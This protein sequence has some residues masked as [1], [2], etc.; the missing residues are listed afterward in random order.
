ME[1]SQTSFLGRGWS[2]PPTFDPLTASVRMVSEEED[3]IESLFILFTTRP[4]ERV[5]HPRYGCDLFSQVFERIDTLTETF[6]EGLI[7]DA[8]LYFEPRI[9]LEEV[10][11]NEDDAYDGLL[12]IRLVY[13]VRKTNSRSNV[14]FPFYLR[15][16][17]HV[18]RE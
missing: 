3:I 4:G 12:Y 14:T 8:V 1:L 16:A 9:T 11:F 5:M 15:E 10:H 13:T 18:I 6:I 17:T 7:A 2:F